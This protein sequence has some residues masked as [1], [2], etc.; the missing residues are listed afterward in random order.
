MFSGYLVLYIGC[1]IGIV[2]KKTWT[3]KALLSAFSI[4]LLGSTYSL[5]RALYFWERV[6]QSIV[7]LKIFNS[8]IFPVVIL[9]RKRAD[10]SHALI[11]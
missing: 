6:S 5:I 3:R 10:Y 4:G 11:L 8:A 1:L 2:G 9:R 7:G